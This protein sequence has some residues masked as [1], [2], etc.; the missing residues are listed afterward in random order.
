MRTYRRHLGKTTRQRRRYARTRASLA[1]LSCC[2]IECLNQ[3]PELVFAY[4]VV[5]AKTDAIS[6]RR[7][8]TANVHYALGGTRVMTLFWIRASDLRASGGVEYL[9]VQIER[10]PYTAAIKRYRIAP[11]C[12]QGRWSYQFHPGT[13]RTCTE[14]PSHLRMR[15]V[16]CITQPGSRTRATGG[17]CGEARS[18]ER[19]GSEARARRVPAALL[20]THRP[21]ECAPRR[22]CSTTWSRRTDPPRCPT[23]PLVTSQGPMT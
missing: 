10:I 6:E 20:Y 15:S 7:T 22:R 1:E 17:S 18:V 12:P 2:S 23:P 11:A 8:L 9:D 5:W 3:W 16:S 19:T 13:H 14:C 4:T 21:R